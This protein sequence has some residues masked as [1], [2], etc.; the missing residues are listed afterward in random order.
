M[1][2]PIAALVQTTAGDAVGDLL[3]LLV[4]LQLRHR[5]AAIKNLSLSAVKIQKRNRGS[6]KPTIKIVLL[7]EAIKREEILIAKDVSFKIKKPFFGVGVWM[8]LVRISFLL[9][10]LGELLLA[11]QFWD[12]VK[13]S[14]L[15]F[16]EFLRSIDFFFSNNSAF[17]KVWGH[18]AHTALG[19]TDTTLLSFRGV[20]FQSKAD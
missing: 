10:P 9:C 2:M 14:F 7:Q 6:V 8:I 15:V 12:S 20:K 1:S 18:P 5:V 16:C 3:T 17:P 4:V 13:H 11:T 19:F